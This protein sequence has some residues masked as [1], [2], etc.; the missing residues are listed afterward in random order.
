MVKRRRAWSLLLVLGAA[1]I[2]FTAAQEPP[3]ATEP[4]GVRMERADRNY[5]PVIGFPETALQS[6]VATFEYAPG[7]RADLYWPPGFA[8]E[9]SLPVVLFV[10]SVSDSIFRK[11]LGVCVA[12]TSAYVSWCAAAASRGFAA[13]VMTVNQ[14]SRDLPVLA[15]WLESRKAA[16]RLDTGRIFLWACSANGDAAVAL[17]ASGGALEGR[18]AGMTLYYTYLSQKIG[19]ASCRERV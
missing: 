11:E 9:K 15:A 8:F 17:A 10:V 6:R 14:W 7:L 16:L 1:A 3:P 2:F 18:V 19:R 12:E 13:V 5:G 4:A